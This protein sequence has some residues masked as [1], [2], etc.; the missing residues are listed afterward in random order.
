MP[1]KT[2]QEKKAES[3]QKDRR[4]VYGENDKASRK[5]LPRKKRR[6]NRAERRLAREALVGNAPK[7]DL[8]RLDRAQTRARKKQLVVGVVKFP[9]APLADFLE[10]QIKER[11]KKGI[12]SEK[13]AREKLARVRARRR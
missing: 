1:R 8:D 9:D 2:P 5:N 6:Q 12:L 13:A 7:M 10:R 11:R 3:Y 4:N